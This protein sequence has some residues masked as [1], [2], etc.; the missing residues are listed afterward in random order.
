M[1]IV[2]EL[3]ENDFHKSE[4]KATDL[5]AALQR[6][7]DHFD[8]QVGTIHGYQAAADLL[9]LGASVGIPEVIKDKVKSIAIGKG[10]AGIAA[11]RMEPVQINSIQTDECGGVVRPGAKMIKAEGAIAVPIIYAG[12]LKGVL[13]MA[14]RTPYTFSEEEV[15]AFQVIC[16]LLSTYLDGAFQVDSRPS[17][18]LHQV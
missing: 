12:Q 8:C 13:G 16:A 17:L 14:K 18:A 1:D 10:I 6:I 11:E 7:L 15:G 3:I 9:H 5:Q 4:K 2:A